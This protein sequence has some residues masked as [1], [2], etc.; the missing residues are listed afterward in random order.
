MNARQRIEALES[1]DSGWLLVRVCPR[2]G[3]LVLNPEASEMPTRCTRGERHSPIPAPS[4]RDIA[5]NP[6]RD[7]E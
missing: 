5:I 3:E 1:R 4:P 6:L 7:Y 2:C